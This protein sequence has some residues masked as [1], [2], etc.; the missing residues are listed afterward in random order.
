[1]SDP[2]FPGPEDIVP[3][4][5]E[6]GRALGAASAACQSA[7]HW[8]TYNA[9]ALHDPTEDEKRGDDREKCR[10]SFVYIA[11]LEGVAKELRETH[12]KLSVLADADRPT[13]IGQGFAPFLARLELRAGD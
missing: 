5:A 6:H 2:H 7:S 12:L 8:L 1:M 11:E 9:H 4:L 13:S 3:V 10:P